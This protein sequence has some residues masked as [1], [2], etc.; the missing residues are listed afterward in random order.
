MSITTRRGDDGRT[1]LMFG[2]RISKID[3]RVEAIGSVDELN[4]ALGLARVESGSDLDQSIDCLQGYLVGLM[5]ELAVLPEDNKRYGESGHPSIGKDAVAMLDETQRRR[6]VE[7]H[8][9]S[10]T[11]N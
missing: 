7:G 6:Q 4:A 11:K 3:P 8:S 2:K 1:D 9:R 10:R 5:G